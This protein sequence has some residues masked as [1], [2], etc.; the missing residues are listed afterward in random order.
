MSWKKSILKSLVFVVCFLLSCFTPN[1]LTYSSDAEYLQGYFDYKLSSYLVSPGKTVKVQ[2][3]YKTDQ[4][5]ENYFVVRP[6]VTNGQTLIYNESLNEF[7]NAVS[8]TSRLPSLKETVLIK[9]LPESDKL[10][11]TLSFEI[12]NVQKK[13]IYTTPEKQIWLATKNAANIAKLNLSILNR[14]LLPEV[15]ITETKDLLPENH[16]TSQ[17]LKTHLLDALIY[18]ALGVKILL[19]LLSKGGFRHF[20]SAGFFS[21]HRLDRL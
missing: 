15:L 8:P 2:I 19:W 10:S 4:E 21:G 7:V 11:A 12:E 9:L 5:L 3:L 17:P 1:V 20:L 6:K 13:T 16:K 18:T 14:D